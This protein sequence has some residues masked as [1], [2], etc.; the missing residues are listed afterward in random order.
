MYSWLKALVIWFFECI[1][2]AQRRTKYKRRRGGSDPGW[3]CLGDADNPPLYP[4]WGIELTALR[5]LHD[6]KQTWWNGILKAKK[7]KQ[8]WIFFRILRYRYTVHLNRIILK[9]IFRNTTSQ[10]TLNHLKNILYIYIYIYAC[11]CIVYVT[12]TYI[13]MCVCVCFEVFSY[14]RD[15]I[16]IKVFCC[17]IW[18]L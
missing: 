1:F 6:A 10:W 17:P 11:V 7:V 2:H 3:W 12:Y 4:S 14:C 15:N 5:F 16:F 8:F 18:L 13:Y 9:Y